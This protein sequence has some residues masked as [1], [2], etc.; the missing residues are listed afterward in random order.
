MAP[1]TP[2]NGCPSTTT[3][4]TST[5][6]ARTTT[7]TS[8][9]RSTSNRAAHHRASPAGVTAFER[10]STPF[11]FLS[12]LDEL[13]EDLRGSIR[14]EIRKSNAIYAQARP[15]GR[16]VLKGIPSARIEE[17]EAFGG[18][19]VQAAHERAGGD[20]LLF[21]VDEPRWPKA[22][23]ALEDHAL[24]ADPQGGDHRPVFSR[25]RPRREPTLEPPTPMCGD[26]VLA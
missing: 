23:Q 13:L 8:S 18:E 10:S 22:Q 19:S 12:C 20:S 4:R 24:A 17:D 16:A 2:T 25:E 6:T 15:Q 1:R 26:R 14:Q 11:P 21:E 3:R 9:S 5:R 7:C